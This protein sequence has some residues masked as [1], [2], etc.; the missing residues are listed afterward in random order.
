[1]RRSIPGRAAAAI[2][3][4]PRSAAAK[5]PALRA[6]AHWARGA[7]TR[8]A[9]GRSPPLPE[10]PETRR[11]ARLGRTG[12]SAGGG[13]GLLTSWIGTE[14]VRTGTTRTRSSH[15]LETS[16]P[17]IS[18]PKSRPISQSSMPSPARTL[19][20]GRWPSPVFGGFGSGCD[21]RGCLPGV[22]FSDWRS[23]SR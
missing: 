22:K 19:V 10:A 18:S 7:G 2:A 17:L 1:M 5:R 21:S 23:T 12:A 9:T 16:T 3:R 8:P 6:G 14:E 4:F 20:A 11:G 15:S 13:E